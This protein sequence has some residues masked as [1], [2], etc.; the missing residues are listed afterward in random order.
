MYSDGD[1]E[2]LMKVNFESS[3]YE[4]VIYGVND[5]IKKYLEKLFPRWVLEDPK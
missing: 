1:S 5:V 3:C 4:Y 2:L